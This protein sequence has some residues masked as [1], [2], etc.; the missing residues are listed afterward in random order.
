MK[1]PTDKY[2]HNNAP[3]NEMD[4]IGLFFGILHSRGPQREATLGLGQGGRVVNHAD[5]VVSA[6]LLELQPGG[7]GVGDDVATYGLGGVLGETH[8]IRI[9]HHLVGD[10]HR[11]AELLREAGQLS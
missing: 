6:A 8:S 3:N 7:G 9:G 11:D 5:T 4:N 2:V 10:H 1:P